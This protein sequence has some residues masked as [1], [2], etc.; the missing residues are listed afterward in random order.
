MSKLLVLADESGNIHGALL[1]TLQTQPGAPLRIE[2]SPSEGQA[3]YEV[4][5]PEEIGD[6]N[7]AAAALDA[8]YVSHAEGKPRLVKHSTNKTTSH[9]Q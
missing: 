5:M 1:S 7:I 4:A 8:Y 6:L 9:S 3:V 2:M